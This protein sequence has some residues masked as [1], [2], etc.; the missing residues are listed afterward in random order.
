MRIISKFHDY[1]DTVQMFGQD[2]TIIYKR[3]KETIKDDS[4]V[5]LF[6]QIPKDRYN[7]YKIIPSKKLSFT[8]FLISFCGTVHFG[9]NVEGLSYPTNYC[10]YDIDEIENLLLQ[11]ETNKR[12]DA[13]CHPYKGYR[14]KLM[15][16][17]FSKQ[18]ILQ[19]KEEFKNKNLVDFHI[20][21]NTPII[22]A[23]K[24]PCEREVKIEINS[25]LKDFQF[26][27]VVDSFNTFQNIFS[28][29]SGIL[30]T[31]GKEIPEISNDNK[32]QKS[33]FDKWSFRKEKK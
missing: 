20:K 21:Y 19:T 26:Y 7:Y 9:Y 29:V 2:Q 23:T 12:S 10:E 31:N 15:F 33:G 5:E 18:S 28:F 1:Y 3:Q 17:H 32:I 27:K 24:S 11:H 13:F 30:T 4:L 8:P 25:C 16:H 22:C 14:N 6:E